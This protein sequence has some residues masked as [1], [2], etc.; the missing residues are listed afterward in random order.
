MQE[1]LGFRPRLFVFIVLLN[2]DNLGKH[3]CCGHFDSSPVY[4]AA[5]GLFE[6][7]QAFPHWVQ[8]WT[9]VRNATVLLWFNIVAS[10]EGCGFFELGFH[11]AAQS[12]RGMLV[13]AETTGP[14]KGCCRFLVS[15]SSTLMG[16]TMKNMEIS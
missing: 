14:R 16:F 9:G 8:G 15:F 7:F 5:R 2:C 13:L 3:A 11:L 12:S 1:I 10:P 6:V 4:R